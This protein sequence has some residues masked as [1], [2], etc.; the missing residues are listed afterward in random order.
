MFLQVEGWA[1]II[2]SMFK[3]WT[4]ISVISCFFFI[5]VTTAWDYCPAKPGHHST[6]LTSVKNGN[7]FK[8]AHP[9]C[10]SLKDAYEVL[11]R[12]FNVTP[13]VVKNILPPPS[14]T[15][16][17]SFLIK[18]LSNLYDRPPPLA[19]PPPSIPLFQL[20]CNLRI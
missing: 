7:Q 14:V 15:V 17:P 8:S 12:A 16:G 19:L 6:F 18:Y 5:L 13:S 1:F 20:H 3:W 10:T 4:V 11:S 9:P 2:K